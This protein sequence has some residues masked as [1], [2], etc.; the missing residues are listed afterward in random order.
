[1]FKILMYYSCKLI[2]LTLGLPC[3][4]IEMFTEFPPKLQKYI[5]DGQC[6]HVRYMVK[7][8]RNYTDPTNYSSLIGIIG[9]GNTAQEECT[10][11][12]IYSLATVDPLN[13]HKPW[14]KCAR[15]YFGDGA[16]WKEFRSC[17]SNSYHLI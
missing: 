11:R 1:M 8:R 12:S 17:W 10:S 7:D 9:V 15:M 4:I 2:V 16:P 14:C 3:T 5:R 6:Y 13:L